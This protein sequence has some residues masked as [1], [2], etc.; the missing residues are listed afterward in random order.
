MATT[1]PVSKDVLEQFNDEKY[2]LKKQK[3]KKMTSEQFVAY[4]LDLSRKVN[5]T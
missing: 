5:K 3:N 1:I 4:L 2:R